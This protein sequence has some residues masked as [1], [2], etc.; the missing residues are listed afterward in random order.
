MKRTLWE[1]RFIDG[2]GASFY[3]TTDVTEYM[4]T[5]G[6]VRTVPVAGRV[7]QASAVSDAAKCFDDG[8]I[9][10]LTA[11]MGAVAYAVQHEVS[12]D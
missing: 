1:L 3:T 2:R 8:P 7:S 10:E 4:G 12:L 5:K 6:I 9:V 11:D